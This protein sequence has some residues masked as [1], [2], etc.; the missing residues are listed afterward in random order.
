MARGLDGLGLLSIENHQY[1]LQTVDAQVQQCASSQLPL[2]QARNVGKWGP[3]IS[4]HHLNI[5][6]LPLG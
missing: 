3:Q 6:Q 1:K 4:P 2:S 5:T